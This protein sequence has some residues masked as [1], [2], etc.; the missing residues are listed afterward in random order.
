MSASFGGGGTLPAAGAASAA[1]AAASVTFSAACSSGGSASL[2]A[3]TPHAV[4][5][6]VGGNGTGTPP[7][8]L[9]SPPG[10]P[11]SPSHPTHGQ[12][13]WL[14]LAYDSAWCMPVHVMFRCRH[15]HR[16]FG[17]W[18]ESHVSC[19]LQSWAGDNESLLITPSLAVQRHH[20][21]SHSG[22]G[23]AA[24]CMRHGPARPAAAAAATTT[25]TSTATPPAKAP[26]QA[27]LRPQPCQPPAAQLPASRP[28]WWNPL[29]ALRLDRRRL[30]P[31]ALAV[32][33]AVA[34]P[35][36]MAPGHRPRVDTAA[37]EVAAVVIIAADDASHLM[38]PCNTCRVMPAAHISASSAASSRQHCTIAHIGTRMA[39]RTPPKH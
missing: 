8:A 26:W 14:T 13:A 7:P 37:A 33:T 30:Q 16:M 21:L 29:P 38:R 12:H 18:L 19:A 3:S 39:T 31:S 36:A 35:Q 11:Y 34:M 1:A 5:G 23:A 17:R 25:T 15:S 20:R 9:K 10:T 32:A 6:T 24:A 27:P 22:P 4:F 2:K 28:E